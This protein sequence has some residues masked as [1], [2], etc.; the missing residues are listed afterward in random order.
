[1]SES[2]F[3]GLDVFNA[4]SFMPPLLDWQLGFADMNAALSAAI[5]VDR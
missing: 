5:V 2:I 4:T 1:M 3:L